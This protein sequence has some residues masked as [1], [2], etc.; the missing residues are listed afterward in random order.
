MH[1]TSWLSVSKTSTSA[2]SNC[3]LY[4][5]LSG[6]PSLVVLSR[7]LEPCTDTNLY[8]Q[9]QMAADSHRYKSISAGFS[10][11]LHRRGGRSMEPPLPGANAPCKELF[12]HSCTTSSPTWWG[13]TRL[14][15]IPPD[16]SWHLHGR[17]GQ[18]LRWCS[19]TG[20]AT[21]IWHWLLGGLAPCSA[22]FAAAVPRRVLRFCGYNIYPRR[23]L[24]TST[25][26][27]AD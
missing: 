19:H 2:V 7:T 27:H 21:G 12:Q 11:E 3:L 9:L 10:W 8:P 25:R 26:Q 4:S 13:S 6:M 16:R 14:T 24:Y 1:I 17:D 20:G 22:P 5:N 23:A 15:S 18:S